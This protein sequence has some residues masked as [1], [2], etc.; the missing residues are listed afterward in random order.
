MNVTLTLYSPWAWRNFRESLNF[1]SLPLLFPFCVSIPF[2]MAPTLLHASSVTNLK[3]DE[4]QIANCFF[5]YFEFSTPRQGQFPL[6]FSVPWAALTSPLPV[7]DASPVR[8]SHLIWLTSCVLLFDPIHT[9]N[10]DL[11][12]FQGQQSPARHSISLLNSREAFIRISIPQ[13]CI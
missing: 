6:N 5:L 12:Y 9:K 4:K 10:N 13:K 11:L 3:Y 2:L 8:P 1:V 7:V